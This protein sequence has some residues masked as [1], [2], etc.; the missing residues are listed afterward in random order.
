MQQAVARRTR[1][2]VGAAYAAQG[3][4]YATVVTAMPGLKSRTGIDDGT[5]SIV[6]LL[7]AVLAAVGSML[8]ER[9]ARRWDSRTPLVVGLLAQAVGLVLVTTVTSVPPLFGAFVVFALGLGMVDASAGMQG[10]ALEQR[11]GRPLMSTLFACLTGAA[12]AAALVQSGLARLGATTGAV[13]ALLVAAGVAAAVALAVRPGLV[14]GADAPAP[15][16]HVAVTPPDAPPAP[17]TPLPRAGIWL[18]GAMVAVAFVVDS[19]VSSWSTVYLH[20]GL[21]ATGAVA[22]LGYAAYQGAVLV[23]RLAGDPL[24]RRFGRARVAGPTVVVAAVG[25]FVVALVPS[26]AA[27]IVGFALAG[28]G[29]GT[30]LPLAFSAAAEL[31]PERRDDVVARINLFNYAGALVGAVALGLLSEVT[32]LGPAFVV[33]AVLLVPALLVVPRFDRPATLAVAGADRSRV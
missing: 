7:G 9:F 3:F 20:D 19:A 23:S 4:G 2:S 31:A 30:L 22:P 32:G 33:P 14:R 13:T 10:V 6:L 18:F 1:V 11:V 28:V 5:I 26:P 25:L 16:A 8:A 12:V 21:G 24:V 17:R 15:A 29:A 27:A